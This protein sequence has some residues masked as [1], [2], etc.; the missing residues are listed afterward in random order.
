MLINVKNIV[1]LVLIFWIIVGWVGFGFLFWY[2]I[3]DGFW[4]FEWLLDGYLFDEDYVF[5]VFLI[6]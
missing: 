2:G 6:V 5:V 4:L 3:E 1:F